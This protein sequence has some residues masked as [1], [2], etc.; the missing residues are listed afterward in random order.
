MVTAMAKKTALEGAAAVQRA[1]FQREIIEC[2][3]AFATASK[4][5]VNVNVHAMT[6]VKKKDGD[7]FS[8]D[9]NVA[10]ITLAHV[11]EHDNSVNTM[12]AS[13]KM[14]LAGTVLGDVFL[15]DYT[16]SSF[17]FS[18]SWTKRCKFSSL[19]RKTVHRVDDYD[20]ITALSFLDGHKKFVAG[21]AKGVV[22]VWSTTEKA[23]PV[24]NKKDAISA[25]IFSEPL[26][27]IQ[28]LPP[29]PNPKT[30]EMC[31]AFSLSY[32]EGRVVSMA[33][34]ESKH[35]LIRF[36]MEDYSP[37]EG[38]SHAARDDNEIH[39]IG[40]SIDESSRPI[41]IAGGD[42]G[43]IHLSKPQWATESTAQ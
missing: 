38:D 39:S 18:R 37:A 21:S 13:P 20:A 36:A 43:G 26:S 19:T 2:S 22:R 5:S 6:V 29:I 40:V 28:G 33:V 4:G 30:G 8:G 17:G 3:G 1:A 42:N 34:S 41:L 12:I 15:W 25:I 11:L 10:E 27:G 7:D 31:L 24:I 32:T 14:I 23:K 9:S 35:E 16:K